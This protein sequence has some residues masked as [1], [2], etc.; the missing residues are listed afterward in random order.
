MEQQLSLESLSEQLM[1]QADKILALEH[2]ITHLQAQLA[3]LDESNEHQQA[4]DDER[5]P[6]Y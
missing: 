6:H 2:K 1:T 4:D 5:P 3:R